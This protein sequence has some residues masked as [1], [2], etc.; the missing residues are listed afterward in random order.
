MRKGRTRSGVSN[1]AKAIPDVPDAPTIGA[2]ANADYGVGVSVPFTAAATGGAVTTYT[3]TST[4]GSVTGTGSSSPIIVSGL[5]TAT[6]YTFTVKGTN[7]SATGPESSASNSATFTALSPAWDSIA[8]L[9]PTG[10]GTASFTS[11]PGTYKHLQIRA[12]VKNTAATTS[13]YGLTLRFNSD[14]GSNYS[15]HLLLGAGGASALTASQNT[16]I[17]GIQVGDII[18]NSY[19]ER[20]FTSMILDIPDYTNTGKYKTTRSF[21]GYT[22][23]SSGQTYVGMCTGS[24]FNTNAITSIDIISSNNFRN[25]GAP[26]TLYLYGMKGA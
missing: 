21:Y 13:E 10:T 8:T 23:N 5:T 25:S 4:P 6:S 7:S 12:T 19:P 14:T 26:S 22:N 16:G 17:T 1:L 15:Q 9:A 18:G 11:I 20:L 2:A 24:W 3:V